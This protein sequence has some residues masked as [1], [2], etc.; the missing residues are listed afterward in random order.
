MSPQQLGG[1]AKHV[2]P[3]LI[4]KNCINSGIVCS[5][6]FLFFF[7]RYKTSGSCFERM[8]QRASPGVRD[9]N[10][11]NWKMMWQSHVCSN[12]HQNNHLI[13]VITEMTMEWETNTKQKPHRTPFEKQQFQEILFI[14]FAAV[15]LISYHSCLVSVRHWQCCWIFQWGLICIWGK[16][17]IFSSQKKGRKKLKTIPISPAHHNWL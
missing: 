12:I 5:F 11:R 7:L 1:A 4:V 16:K 17:I 6:L 14:N 15:F 8:S 3:N 13:Y 9:G 2:C 10:M